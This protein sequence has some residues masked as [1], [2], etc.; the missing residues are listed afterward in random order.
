M[1]PRGQVVVSAGGRL[2]IPAAL[3]EPETVAIHLEDV[4]V[5]RQPVEQRARQPLGTERLGPLVERQVAGHQGRAALVALA[6]DLEEQLGAGLG[7]RNEAELVDDQEFVTGEPLLEP[8]ELLLVARLDELMRER[9]GGAEAD[10]E[11][12]LTGRDR[13]QRGSCRRR[14]RQAQSRSRGDRCTHRER[15]PAPGSC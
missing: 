9:G 3:I 6:E 12:L 5:V 14:C 2:L 8:E 1:G 4:D 13:G 7:Q 15:V 11:A 10:A